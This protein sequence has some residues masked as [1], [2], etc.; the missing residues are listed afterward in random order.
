M[1]CV[2]AG[3]EKKKKM[4]SYDLITQYMALINTLFIFLVKLD[5]KKEKSLTFS[6]L[7][8]YKY[9]TKFSPK[10]R[11]NKGCSSWNASAKDLS[12]R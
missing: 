3:R 10:F 8:Q 2:N 9:Y 7:Y 1:S 6:F 4:Y 12:G 5:K 11:L